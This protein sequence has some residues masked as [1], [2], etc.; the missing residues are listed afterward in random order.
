MPHKRTFDLEGVDLII[1][2][3]VK[4]DLLKTLSFNL[5]PDILIDLISFKNG[6]LFGSL[7]TLKNKKIH[8]SIQGIT[9]YDLRPGAFGIGYG[10]PVTNEL[11][12]VTTNKRKIVT[13]FNFK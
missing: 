8:F 5:A 9:S 11:L 4:S 13:T 6:I 7:I 10:E 1:T 12:F 2:D 3:L